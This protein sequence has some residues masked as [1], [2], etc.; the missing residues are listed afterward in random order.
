MSSTSLAGQLARRRPG[1]D[2]L[3][4]TAHTA[5]AAAVAVVALGAAAAAPAMA[6]TTPSMITDGSNTNIAVQGPDHSLH[7]YW[8]T[9][10]TPAGTPRRSPARAPPS[11]RRR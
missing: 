3:G 2:S 9:N 4:R 10:G 7:F 11:R 6:S 8:A 1:R 5:S